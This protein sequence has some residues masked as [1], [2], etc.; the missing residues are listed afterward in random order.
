MLF[1]IFNYV[2]T[3]SQAVL[4][5]NALILFW[6]FKG[7][8]EKVRSIWPYIL[9]AFLTEI[10]SKALAL[11]EYPNLFLLHIYTLLEF[12][13]WSFFYRRVFQDNKRFQTIFP[14][15]VAVIAVLLIGN[16]IF[17]EPLNTFNSNAKT[18]V[19][20]ALISYGVYYLFE[21]FGKTDLTKPTQR[22]V[23]LIN[24][25]VI[26]YYSGS[27]FIFMFSKFL[28]SQHVD[29]SWQRLMWVINALLV[30]LFQVLIFFGLWP[31]AFGKKNNVHDRDG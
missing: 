8:P 1:K 11:L 4:L 16:S 31:F 10:I 27:L 14:W 9:I 21:A 29:Q 23:I 3:I 20:V 12:L 13:T 15:A 2:S 18:L 22:A 28:A 30:G 17:L 6:K 7:I 25:A 19:Q 5:L 24:F 26:L